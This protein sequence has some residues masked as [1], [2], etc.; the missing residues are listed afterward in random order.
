MNQARWIWY[1]GDYELYHSLLLHTRREDDGFSY[2]CF[3]HLATPYAR[4]DFQRDFVAESAGSFQA[5]SNAQGHL[6]LDGKR[7]PLHQQ[8]PVSPGHH[9]LQVQ[10]IKYDGLPCLYINSPVL[11]TDSSWKTSNA[12]TEIVPVGCAPAYL[13]PALTPE[14]F[15][16]SYQ[17]M[18]PI[19][20]EEKE[21][22][23]IYDFGKELFGCLV[24]ENADPSNEISVYYGES[25]EEALDTEYTVLWQKVSRQGSIPSGRQG[26]PVYI[27]K[28]DRERQS[29][30]MG[31][32]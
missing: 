28:A 31:G 21:Q 24:I 15:L 11:T 2:P 4:V 19:G 1:P 20:A 3:W 10:L 22:G 6:I 14:T 16:F 27:L 32:L 23:A 18:E 17:K 8:V 26:V 12:T 7:Y 5:E 13:D 29:E 30:N 25:E 9:K